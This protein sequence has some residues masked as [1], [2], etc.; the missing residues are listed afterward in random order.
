MGSEFT[1]IDISPTL[2]QNLDSINYLILIS[3]L[4]IGIFGLIVIMAIINYHYAN[5]REKAR[6]FSII[7]AIGGTSKLI[8][9]IIFYED[10]MIILLSSIIAFGVSMNFNLLFL[11]DQPILPPIWQFLVIWLI[12]DIILT[13]LI[14]LITKIEFKN[15]RLRNNLYLRVFDA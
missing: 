6:D 12:I 3:W 5:F 15:I 13:I 4:F 10:F 1:A 11:M 14:R 7:R 9:E 2:Q 8:K